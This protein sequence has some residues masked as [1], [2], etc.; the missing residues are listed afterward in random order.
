MERRTAE[1]QT[2]VLSVSFELGAAAGEFGNRTMRAQAQDIGADGIGILTDCLLRK[3][4][5]LRLDF[6]VSGLRTPLPVF[7]E[8]AWA[9]AANDRFRAGLRFL[10]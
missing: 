5:V 3:G 4:T 10:R 9:I 8:V 2:L 7:A 1:R 6:P